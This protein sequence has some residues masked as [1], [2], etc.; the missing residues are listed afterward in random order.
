MA[1]PLIA[2]QLVTSYKQALALSAALTSFSA[3]FIILLPPPLDAANAPSSADVTTSTAASKPSASS[4]ATAASKPTASQGSSISSEGLLA[5]VR[6]PVLQTRGAQ[7]LMALRLLMAFAFHMWAPVWQVSI[8]ERFDFQPQDHAKFMGV[9][10]LTYAVS[11][12][13]VSKPLIR[14]AGR[15]PT[16]L[17][18][19]CVAL[20]GGSRPFAL[21]TSSMYVVYALYIPMVLALGVMNTAISAACSSLADGDQLGGLFGVLESVESVAGM[22]GPTLGGLA[23]SVHPELPLYCVLFSYAMAFCLVSL[24]FAKHVVR[25]GEAKGE[26]KGATSEQTSSVVR[27]TPSTLQAT[28]REAKKVR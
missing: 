26:A 3:I 5:F 27:A 4:T 19:L 20:L 25:A 14:R 24:F 8:R 9:I 16:K 13:A 28:G 10:G 12:G 6:M 2:T 18:L 11:Q 7:L 15:D 21:Y 1:G 17:L 23:A 22:I